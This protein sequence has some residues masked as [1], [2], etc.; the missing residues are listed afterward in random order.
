MMLKK[1]LPLLFG[2]AVFLAGCARHSAE[3]QRLGVAD[4]VMEERPDS[5]LAILS[6]IDPSVLASPEE[7]ACY[8]LLLTQTQVKNGYLGTNDSLINIALKFYQGRKNSNEL[9]RAYFYTADLLHNKGDLDK[10]MSAL[11]SSLEIS[12]KRNDTY[13]EAK[14]SELMGDVCSS[15]YHLEDCCHYMRKASDLYEKAD[16]R[17]NAHYA[18][19]DYAT[20][21]AELGDTEKAKVMIDSM[22][23]NQSREPIDSAFM[24]YCLRARIPVL[25]KQRQT[26]EAIENF[27]CLLTLDEYY[28]PEPTWYA[29]IARACLSEDKSEMALDYLT[30]A[31]ALSSTSVER[32]NIEAVWTQYFLHEDDFKRAA[33]CLQDL[34]QTQNQEVRALLKES[35]T[36]SQRDYYTNKALKEKSRT[37]LLT[38][39]FIGCLILMA[40][41]TYVGISMYKLKMR[42]NSIE[43]KSKIQNIVILT[44][45]LK[46]T[47]SENEVLNSK[48]GEERF[49]IHGLNAQLEKQA[50]QI[51]EQKQ[52]M[53]EMRLNNVHLSEYRKL[54]DSIKHLFQGSWKLLNTLSREFLEKEDSEK[55]RS[56]I[57]N[58]IQNEIKKIKSPKNLEFI[59]STVNQYMDGI[60]LKLRQ[61]CKSIKSDD[62]TLITLTLAGLSSRAVS[63]ILEI[64]NNT[65]YTRRRRMLN[66]IKVTSP[67]LYNKLSN[68]IP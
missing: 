9:M 23:Q 24:A 19:V 56:T 6:A 17:T 35:V 43:L 42:A 58:E 15:A 14:I 50:Q 21:L 7:N 2:I 13:W 47:K 25:L 1:I 22:M 16:K 8:A 49:K 32:A 33:E 26:K 57:L 18:L 68:L 38:Y 20:A 45:S 44:S 37:T 29:K 53:E 46:E 11:M 59:E 54:Q 52:S 3:W 36:A 63:L 41:I 64:P 5:A 55:M 61:E 39:G 12:Q 48:L 30:K 65:Y 67:D 28:L 34:L 66:S 51:E 10:S 40:L 4:A 62:I 31:E 60:I 27:D